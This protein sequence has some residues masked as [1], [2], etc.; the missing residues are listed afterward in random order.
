[1]SAL[2]EP[3]RALA[4]LGG[5]VLMLLLAVSVIAVA[6]I[7]LKLMQ[8]A[9]ARVGRH[10][11]ARQAVALW[12]GNRHREALATIGE[13]RSLV[14][15]SVVAAMGLAET[16]DLARKEIEE[17][18]SRIALDGLHELQR[19]L[20][21]LEAIAQTAPLLGLFGTVLGMIEAFRELQAA[22]NAVDPAALAGGIWVALLTTAAGL[23]IAMPVS[24]VLT[25]LESRVEDEK[26][27]IESL[28]AAVLSPG[29]ETDAQP[30]GDRLQA[31]HAT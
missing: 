15:R 5:P 7:A 8:F 21:A 29:G 17:E 16:G 12:R 3:L 10:S 19:G 18:V 28:V 24:L 6:L 22:G 26:A 4:G 13:G 25:W 2:L 31:L 27:G 1:M 30:A 11:A 14:E 20:R 9:S 23:A